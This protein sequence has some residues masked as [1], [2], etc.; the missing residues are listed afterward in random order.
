MISAVVEHN[1]SGLENGHL[2]LALDILNLLQVSLADIPAV[3]LAVSSAVSHSNT[4]I[5]AFTET[6]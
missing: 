3:S 1:D 6:N 4:Y 5:I 2:R